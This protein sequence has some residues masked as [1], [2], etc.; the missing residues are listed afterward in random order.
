MKSEKICY[1]SADGQWAMGIGQIF[2]CSKHLWISY[3][4]VDSSVESRELVSQ[5]IQETATLSAERC[6]EVVKA[7]IPEFVESF[8]ELRKLVSQTITEVGNRSSELPLLSRLLAVRGGEPPV[9]LPSSIL[10]NTK[11][12]LTTLL[13]AVVKIFPI[14]KSLSQWGYMRRIW[15]RTLADTGGGM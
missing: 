13:I 8:V 6:V 5:T 2:I 10:D 14:L 9:L 1:K 11:S 15:D 4:F 12:G 3:K 7:E